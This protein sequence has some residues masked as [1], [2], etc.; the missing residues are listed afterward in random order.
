MSNSAELER[1]AIKLLVRIWGM[2]ERDAGELL[3][4]SGMDVELACDAWLEAGERLAQD[5]AVGE[6][7]PKAD[8]LA[9]ALNY[10]SRLR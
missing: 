1:S 6:P 7:I 10:A 9:L 8:R 3:R 4:A 5:R 2:D